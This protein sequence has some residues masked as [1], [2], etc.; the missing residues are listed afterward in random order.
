[1]SLE[2]IGTVGFARDITQRKQMEDQVRQLA[3]HDA[4]T[5]LPNRRLLLDQVLMKVVGCVHLQ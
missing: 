3:F 4:L 5:G 2:A 1:M